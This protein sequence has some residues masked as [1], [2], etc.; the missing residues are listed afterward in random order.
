[1]DY[2]ITS[3]ELYHHGIL[4]MKWGVRRYQ[5]YPPGHSGGKEIGEAAKRKT[6]GGSFRERRAKKRM[7]EQQSAILQRARAAKDEKSERAKRLEEVRKR[8]TAK[9]VLEFTSELTTQELNELNN[10]IKVIRSLEEIAQKEKD[11]GFNKI[12]EVMKKV[13]KVKDWG[14]IGIDSYNVKNDIFSILDGTYKKPDDKKD[15]KK[16]KKKK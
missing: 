4:G 2:Y 16:D 7:S 6:R 12:D 3:N 11:A 5:P 8:P 14:K 1:M 15:E 10:R 9:A 13:G